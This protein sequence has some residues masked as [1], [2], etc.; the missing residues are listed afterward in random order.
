MSTDQEPAPLPE[1]EQK[2]LDQA[3]AERELR[4]Q[5]GKSPD[6]VS[7]AVLLQRG[8]GMLRP[9]D[10]VPSAGSEGDADGA[11]VPTLK[12][13]SSPSGRCSRQ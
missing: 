11:V 8:P 1:A 4:E 2:A 9:K 6:F 7:A 5:A 13:T 3:N 12:P 10:A